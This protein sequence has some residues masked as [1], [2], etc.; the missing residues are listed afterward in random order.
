LI[1]GEEIKYYYATVLRFGQNNEF[2]W[3]SVNYKNLESCE[4]YKGSTQS[5]DYLHSAGTLHE[6]RYIVAGDIKSG[7]EEKFTELQILV[8]HSP[9]RPSF[10]T[11]TTYYSLRNKQLCIPQGSFLVFPV[12][13]W[14]RNDLIELERPIDAQNCLSRYID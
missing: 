2:G 12:G 5:F 14:S 4:K 8:M 3:F 13:L 9:Q 6:H 7:G 11:K 10:Y 1:Q